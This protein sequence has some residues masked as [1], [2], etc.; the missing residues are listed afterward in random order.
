[1]NSSYKK[2]FSTLE[3]FKKEKL[4]VLLHRG[5]TKKFAFDKF[6][7]DIKFNTIEQ[8][9]KMLFFYGE[10]SRYYWNE[11]I[12][13]QKSDFNFEIN[14]TSDSFFEFI[15]N[16]FSILIKN[17]RNDATI[18]YFQR[19]K[20]IADYF[21]NDKNIKVFLNK[22]KLL[23]DDKKI[24]FRNYYLRIIHQLGET[25]YKK[26][27]LQISSSKNEKKTKEFS[28]DEIVINFWDFN[29]TNQVKHNELPIFKGKP[30]K[31]QEEITIFSVILPHYIYSFKYNDQIYLNPAI[32][33]TINYDIA[34]LCGL[35]IN[36]DDIVEKSKSETNYSNI[37][38]TDGKDYWKS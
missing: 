32:Y 22:I 31:N 11:R 20:E 10:K 7:L 14:D 26:N 5:M 36:Q 2:F 4:I 23:S 12:N 27:S 28:N 16:E 9:S 13:K 25:S 37:V 35:E 6:N 33:N 1:M 34:I 38:F 19:N 21:G 15:F 3:K 24:F 30:Y 29:F 17:P 8:F 18:K